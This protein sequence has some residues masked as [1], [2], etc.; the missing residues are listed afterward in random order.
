MTVRDLLVAATEE[1]GR[2]GVPSPRVDAEWLLA[3]ALGISRTDLYA[4]GI[5]LFEMLTGA[6]PFRHGREKGALEAGTLQA[7]APSAL[8]AE[9]P[10]LLDALVLR[11]LSRDRDRRP[12]SARAVAT[13]LQG[14]RR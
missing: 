5:L 12:A 1:L 6:L 10:P 13:E 3:H 8:S 7:T 11:L 2:V 14:M 4:G 9:V